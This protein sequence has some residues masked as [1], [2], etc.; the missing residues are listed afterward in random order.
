M[1]INA[2]YQLFMDDR[3]GSIEVGKYADFVI[4][5]QNP[6]KVAPET[7]GRIPVLGTWLGGRQV[8]AR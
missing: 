5:E 2:A 3:V 8:W 4:L 7:L 6:R 1:T